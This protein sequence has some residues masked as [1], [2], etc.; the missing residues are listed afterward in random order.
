MGLWQTY[1]KVNH[2]IRR[3]E[4]DANSLSSRCFVFSGRTIRAVGASRAVVGDFGPGL[5]GW[6]Y[7]KPTQTW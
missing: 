2:I 1:T 5:N 7:G 3:E 4:S 6:D